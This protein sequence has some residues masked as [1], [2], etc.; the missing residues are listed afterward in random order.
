MWKVAQFSRVLGKSYINSN[1]QHA[2]NEKIDAITGHDGIQLQVKKHS[3]AKKKKKCAICY[4]FHLLKLG[5][6]I[7]DLENMHGFL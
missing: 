5:K 6:P 2:W 7:I 3:K 4:P 1:S